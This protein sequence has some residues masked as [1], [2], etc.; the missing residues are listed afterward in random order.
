MKQFAGR[1]RSGLL[2]A[3]FLTALLGASLLGTSLLGVS[4]IW[5]LPPGAVAP[6]TSPPRD[7]LAAALESF[8][9]IASYRVTLRSGQGSRAETI[10]YFYKS[11]GLVRMEFVKPHPGALL[12]YDPAAKRVTLRP[13]AFAKR[14]ILVLDPGDRLVKS[15]QGHRVDESDIG[16]LLRRARLLE[17][18]GRAVVQGEENV[19]DRRAIVVNVEAGTGFSL[20]DG[21]RRLRL[22]LDETNWLPLQVKAYGPAGNLIE[23]VLMDDLEPDVR[24]DDSL[25]RLPGAGPGPWP[26][27]P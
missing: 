24:L 21:T 1:A 6:G 8:G 26:P 15:P 10:R 2:R 16:A 20:E 22:D 17:E 18:H 4:P 9:N 27:N 19:G 11:P 25:F 3:F 7:P 14:F 23:D 5:A 13:F 12:L